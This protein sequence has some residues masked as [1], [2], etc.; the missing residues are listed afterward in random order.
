MLWSMISFA[1]VMIIPLNDF[2]E[3]SNLTSPPAMMIP[4]N[5]LSL[6]FAP[7]TTSPELIITDFA[8]LSAATPIVLSIVR[9]FDNM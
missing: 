2:T 4:W 9:L 8:L 7:T 3:L 5:E 1:P 6:L